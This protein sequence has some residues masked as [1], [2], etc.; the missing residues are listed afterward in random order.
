M[1]VSMLAMVDNFTISFSKCFLTC[2]NS[3]LSW[4]ITL[5]FSVRNKIKSAYNFALSYSKSKFFFSRTA[6]SFHKMS[7]AD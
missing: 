5:S 1:L 6:I 7:N 2:L 4:A 3:S